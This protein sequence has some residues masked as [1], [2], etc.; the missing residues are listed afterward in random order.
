MR[1][2]LLYS[3]YIWRK[4][5]ICNKQCSREVFVS[6]KIKWERQ[7]LSLNLFHSVMS[8]ILMLLPYQILWS[9]ILNY[10]KWDILLEFYYESKLLF[11][12]FKV[13]IMKYKCY[14]EKYVFIF[15][16]K[17]LFANLIFTE[18][19]KLPESTIR[20]ICLPRENWI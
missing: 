9:W 10:R 15:I 4:E 6:R 2:L 1:E 17:L 12:S 18:I 5:L 7:R 11:L 19:S 13:I 20:C 3:S 8:W 16:L 14:V